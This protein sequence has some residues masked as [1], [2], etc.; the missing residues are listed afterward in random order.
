MLEDV[1]PGNTPWALDELFETQLSD[2]SISSSSA[3]GL[4]YTSGLPAAT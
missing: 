1:A 4:S 2:N 3:A